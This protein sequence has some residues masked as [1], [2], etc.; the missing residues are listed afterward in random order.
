MLDFRDCRD[1]PMIKIK[2]PSD[3]VLLGTNISK[4]VGER[5]IDGRLDGRTNIMPALPDFLK[6]VSTIVI[7]VDQGLDGRS[8]GL[9]PNLGINTAQIPPR[10]GCIGSCRPGQGIGQGSKLHRLVSSNARSEDALQRTKVPLGETEVEQGRIGN[11]Q[12]EGKFT[13]NFVVPYNQ[14]DWPSI[15]RLYGN[16]AGESLFL[17]YTSSSGGR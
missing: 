1:Y 16:K 17:P 13:N 11:L 8:A 4:K 15:C 10:L 14:N 2:S 7:L 9:L 3:F 12:V 5:N 6:I